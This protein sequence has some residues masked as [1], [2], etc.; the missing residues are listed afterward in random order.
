MTQGLRKNAHDGVY[1]I[2]VGVA[3]LAEK[4]ATY[5]MDMLNHSVF[6]HMKCNYVLSL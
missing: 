2:K 1:A 6:F 3:S 4:L 5:Q